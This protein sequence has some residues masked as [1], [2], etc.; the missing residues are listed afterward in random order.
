[1]ITEREQ[2]ISLVDNDLLSPSDAIILLEGDGYNRYRYAAN[3]YL[4]K[5]APILVFSGGIIDYKYGS[6]PFSDIKT[7]L[8][9]TGVNE[10]DIIHEDKSLNTK[11][12]ADEVIILA[13][14]NGWNK[15]ILVASPE[16]QYRAY[17]TFLKTVLIKELNIL[18]YN[19]SVKNLNWFEKS[20]WGV[21]FDRLG[22]EFERIEK[23]TQ[24]GHLATFK[25]AIIYQQ[26]KER[27]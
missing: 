11:E 8:I 24:Q 20:E 27:Q 17:L 9:E 15:I 6:F 14:K 4:K 1:M 19:A 5:L 23:Y 21:R 13:K 16:H 3:L 10:K 2:F 18:I 25:E 7:K 26:W 22:Q 12:Q